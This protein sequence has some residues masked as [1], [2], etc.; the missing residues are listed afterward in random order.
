MIQP[1]RIVN[2]VCKDLALW[3]DAS[4]SNSR[5]QSR[6]NFDV[7]ATVVA[8]LPDE[9]DK[10]W[11]WIMLLSSN[12]YGWACLPNSKIHEYIQ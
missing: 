3:P 6:W 11:S 4:W 10:S 9:Y 2:V 7:I 12:G 1:G 8:I 5:P